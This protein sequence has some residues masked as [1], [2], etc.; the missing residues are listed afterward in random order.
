MKI[1][2]QISYS[3]QYNQFKSFT[4]I[5]WVSKKSTTTLK[6]SETPNIPRGIRFWLV[7]GFFLKRFSNFEMMVVGAGGMGRHGQDG[8]P[9]PRE[10]S[11]VY[12]RARGLAVCPILV[13]L[14][15]LAFICFWFCFCFC[16][17]LPLWFAFVFAFVF[18]FAFLFCNANLVC[19][20][21]VLLFSLVF[22]LFW[23]YFAYVFAFAFLCDL[24]LF[25]LLFFLL[26]SFFVIQI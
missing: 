21:L 24:L 5:L 11:C 23:F 12:L 3:G 7:R 6:F 17:Y 13:L 14:F 2:F 9:S 18:P 19:P 15:L 4:A 16:F 10:A 22:T 26:I 20:I 25:L 8:I 1:W